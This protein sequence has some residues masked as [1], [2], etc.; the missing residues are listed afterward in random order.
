MLTQEL[1]KEVRRLQVRTRRRV[2]GLFAGEYHTAFK[3]RG[4]EFADV[5]EYEPGD[6]VRSIDWNVTA[7]AGRPFIKRFIEERELTVVLAVDLS[8]SGD[9]SSISGESARLKNRVAI[10][11]AAV[12]ALSAST[13]H[14]RVGLCLFT[15]KVEVFVP[16]GKGRGHIL[17]LLRELLNFEPRRRGTDIG[18]AALHLGRVLNRRGIVF[19][20]SDFLVR[21]GV[22]EFE[23]PLRLLA[24]R[25]EVIALQVTDP[26]EHAL[27]NVGLVEI[28]DAET[29][30]RRLIDT[31]SR[32]VRDAYAD[33]ARTREAALASFFGRAEIDRVK[34]STDR[35]FAPELVNYF[36]MRERR[37]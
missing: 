29:G 3:G 5:R 28:V 20:I 23:T 21:G 10:E 8:A 4:I 35:P 31:A 14:D 19:M 37:R 25:H 13:N 6:D 1:M 12:L 2:E 24:R 7:R 16:P 11:A 34:L 9:F 15:E 30:N 17:R 32:R 36:H 26:R 22:P 27:P 33:A 18:S